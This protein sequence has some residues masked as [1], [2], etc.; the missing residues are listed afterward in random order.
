MP[1]RPFLAPA[2]IVLLIAAAPGTLRADAAVKAVPTPDLSKL[3]PAR[4]DELRKIRTSFEKAR[5]AQSGDALAETYALLGTAYAR[6]GFHEAADIALDDAAA[7]A[8]HDGR[9]VYLRGMVAVMQKQDAVAKGYFE[10]ALV[11]DP[12]YLPI[13]TAIASQR[14]AAGNLDGARQVLESYSSQHPEQS[15]PLAM[16]GDIALRQ[17]R[18]AD[19][20]TQLKRAL[21]LAPD[22]NRL[23]A[24][25]ADAY[26][27]S[28]DAKA[29]AEARAKAGPNAPALYDPVGHG[30]IGNLDPTQAT[31][32]A[33]AVPAAAAAQA[34]NTPA[35][36]VERAIGETRSLMLAHKYDEARKRL[37][38]ALQASPNT[39]S[40]IVLYARVE[41]EA[42]NLPAAET[43][44]KQALTLDPKDARAY[45]VLGLAQ[46]MR[47]DDG[48]AQRSYE[49]AVQLQPKNA[50]A[51]I[52]LGVLFVRLNRLDD[53][54]AQFRA[55]TQAGVKSEEAWTRLIAAQF[56]AGR[57]REALQEVNSALKKDSNSGYLLQL[58]VRTASTCPAVGADEK[59]M[60]LDYG[61]NLYLSAPVAPVSEAYALALAANGRWDDAVKTQQGTMFVIM[62]DEGI[63]GVAPYKAFMQQFQAHK[64]PDRPW[65][66]DADVF[67]PRRPAPLAAAPGTAAP[68]KK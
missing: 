25:L 20:I 39:V 7:L 59:R 50:S 65:P 10:R 36:P 26:T 60:A 68:A 4:A 32:T 62:R 22:A 5:D 45:V 3:A 21:Q 2:L 61:G 17:K 57:C 58:F 8:P 28:G 13:R 63:R 46:E 27:A 12:D 51:R 53:A 9:W 11:I 29:A 14:M 38:Q 1:I 33:P 42:G 19:A 56:V 52:A 54:I 24:S 40:L 31:L 18:Y 6:N 49:Q 16:L 44:A 43:R 55:L 66:A 34:P 41:A 47:N 64:L 67:N 23:Y 48:G 37:D 35:D 30:L 15:V